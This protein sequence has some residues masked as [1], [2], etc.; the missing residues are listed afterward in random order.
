M[1]R[2]DADSYTPV[3]NMS[4]PTGSIDPVSGTPFDL[5]TETAVVPRLPSVPGDIGFDHNFVL[6][7]P[8]W[9]KHVAR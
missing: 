5:T 7:K 2:I 9:D 3:D 1:I 6:G 8:G 4:I